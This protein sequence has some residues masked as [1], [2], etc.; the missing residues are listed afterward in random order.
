MAGYNAPVQVPATATAAIHQMLVQLD[1]MDSLMEIEDQPRI[2]INSDYTEPAIPGGQSDL[3]IGQDSLH[4]RILE[5]LR[6]DEYRYN[7][8][9][10]GWHR[11]LLQ[12]SDL[13]DDFDLDPPFS[14][15]DYPRF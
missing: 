8:F 11:T 3:L 10:L 15:Y 2:Y 7:R 5:T 13:D 1:A 9:A 12:L 6:D 4:N 14:L